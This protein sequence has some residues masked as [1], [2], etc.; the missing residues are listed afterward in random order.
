MLRSGR[1]LPEGGAA[2]VNISSIVGKSGWSN[3]GAYAASKAGVIA[4]TKTV[5]QELAHCGIRCNAVLPGWTETPM[6]QVTR[7]EC[8]AMVAS[9]TPLKRSA[10]PREI[11]E[12][13]KFL[14]LP[15]ASSFVTGAVMEVSGGLF[16]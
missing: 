10:Q 7:D 16:M 12:A 5:A 3:A 13:V 6:T 1:A 11:A 9:M 15:A 2:I 4:L 8:R 14:C